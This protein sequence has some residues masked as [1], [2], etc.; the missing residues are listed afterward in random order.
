MPPE[1]LPKDKKAGRPPTLPWPEP[2]PDTIENVM[3]AVL[4]TPPKKRGEWKYL[5]DKSAAA[6]CSNG[7]LAEGGAH[8]TR[9]SGTNGG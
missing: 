4:T 9:S 6:L 5:Q 2:I 3:D 8:D 7:T 1:R